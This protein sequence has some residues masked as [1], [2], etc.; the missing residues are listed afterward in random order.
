[1]SKANQR[2]TGGSGMNGQQPGGNT[3]G[4]KTGQQQQQEPGR[5]FERSNEPSRQPDAGDDQDPRIQEDSDPRET[6][7]PRTS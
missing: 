7:D 1:M 4:G 2:N 3:G 5:K 6:N